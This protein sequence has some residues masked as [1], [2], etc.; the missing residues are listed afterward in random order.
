[1]LVS[2][3]GLCLLV[4]VWVVW[5]GGCEM[6]AFPTLKRALGEPRPLILRTQD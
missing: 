1:V 5:C 6:R 4:F 3:V 2:G